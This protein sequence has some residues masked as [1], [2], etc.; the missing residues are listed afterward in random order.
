MLEATEG[1]LGCVAKCRKPRAGEEIH[2]GNQVF[3]GPLNEEAWNQLLAA[4]VRYESVEVFKNR[5]K[6]TPEKMIP[7]KSTV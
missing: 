3:K 2:R 7:N 5:V 1:F 6:G 4:I